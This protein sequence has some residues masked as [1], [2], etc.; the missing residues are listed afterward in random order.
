MKS[1]KQPNYRAKRPKI[2]SFNLTRLSL[3]NLNRVRL[4][5]NAKS[6]YITIVSPVL[7]N[8]ITGNKA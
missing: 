6:P 4:L 5:N 2:E 7:H 3:Q 8:P 1:S